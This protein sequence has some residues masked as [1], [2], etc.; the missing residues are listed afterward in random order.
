MTLEQWILATNKLLREWLL[1]D[2]PVTEYIYRPNEWYEDTTPEEAV[3][4]IANKYD[5]D[6]C[7][8]PHRDRM[9]Y[10]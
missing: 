10:P 6:I 9:I 8:G 3:L 4:W 5:L 7:D 1:L 2:M